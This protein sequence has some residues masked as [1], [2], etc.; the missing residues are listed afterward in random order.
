[1]NK[2]EITPVQIAIRIVIIIILIVFLIL[3]S[4]AMVRMVPKVFTFLSNARGYIAGLFSRG[5]RIAVSLDKDVVEMGEGATL[6]FTKTGGKN[7]G[8][9]TVSFSCAKISSGTDLQIE[10][11]DE[12]TIQCDETLYIGNV[13][14]TSSA[15]DVRIAPIGDVASYD[16]PMLISIKHLI[17]STTISL[18]S[19]TLTIKGQSLAEVKE[20]TEQDTSADTDKSGDPVVTNTKPAAS[21]TYS[22]TNTYANAAPAN[23]N[24]YITGATINKQVNQGAILFNVTNA[25]GRP[26]GAWRFQATLPRSVGQ[27]IYTSPYQPSIPPGGTSQMNLA[28]DNAKTGPLVITLYGYG[29]T[30]TYYFNN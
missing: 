21:P 22:N 29:D 30:Q 28:F 15:T 16:Q 12:R 23:L 18:G 19:A 4:F 1:M 6:T 3:I 9:Y 24:M 27:T 25:G 11:A 7:E 8:I 13:N 10:S 2:N 14:A 17:G 5:E 26:S 20:D